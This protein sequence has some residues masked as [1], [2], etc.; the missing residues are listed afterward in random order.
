[1]STETVNRCPLC[2]T[3]VEVEFVEEETGLS[4]VGEMQSV[5]VFCFVLFSSCDKKN[6]Q[7]KLAERGI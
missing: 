1:M 7:D 6:I 5:T 4:G 3:G 2:I